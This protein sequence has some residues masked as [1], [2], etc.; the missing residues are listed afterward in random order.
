MEFQT[1]LIEGRLIRRYKRFLADIALPDGREV[2]AHCANSGAMTGMAEPGMPVWVEDVTSPTRKLSHSWKLVAPSDGHLALVD[3][4]M[5]NRVVEE[6]LQ[7]GLVAELAGFPTVRREVKLGEKSR[8]DFRLDGPE[9]ARIWVEVKSVTLAGDDGRGIFPD[10]KTERGVKHLK[11]L[12]EL[13][14]D[15]GQA[16][17]LF[18]MNRSDCDRF[19]VAGAVDAVYAAAFDAARAAGV[20]MLCYGT[21]I[22]PAGVWLDRPLPVDPAPQSSL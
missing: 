11:E 19:G 13:V 10:A 8:I 20:T 2:V 1:P 16:A 3:T 4:G 22:T 9:G 6:A 15:G 7:A 17:M 14:R 5:A 12:T 18:V 21:R